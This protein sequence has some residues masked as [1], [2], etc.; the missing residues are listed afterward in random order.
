MRKICPFLFCIFCSFQWGG[1]SGPEA[2]NSGPRKFR[3]KHRKFRPI[4]FIRG[5]WLSLF[6]VTLWRGSG[7]FSGNFQ[8]SG[9]SGPWSGSS[10]SRK[11]WLSCFRIF[12]LEGVQNFAPEV[13]SEIS[14]GRKFRPP[15]VPALAPEYPAHIFI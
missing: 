15:E 5:F 11:I 12:S 13:S 3:P 1:S 7:S 14:G 4:F 6:R 10:G 9:N 8:G 2:G